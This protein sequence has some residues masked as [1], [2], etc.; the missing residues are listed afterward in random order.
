MTDQTPSSQLTEAAAAPNRGLKIALAVSVAI[1]LA[2]AGL[3]G[4][5]A[6]HGGP[7]G[8]GDGMV[9]DFGFGPFNDALLP[10]D[11]LALRQSVV[12]KIGDIRA[13]RQQMQADGTA[14]LSALRSDPFDPQTLSVALETQGL[15]T[16]ERLK[17]GSDVIRAFILAMSPEARASFADRLERRMRRG[18]DAETD[19][20]RD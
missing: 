15:H 7:G 18:Q 14:I 11:R 12:G 3:V 10:E 9:R 17:F 16:G 19:K 2:I 4:V 13:A 6:W 8:R 5:I 1:N 20:P